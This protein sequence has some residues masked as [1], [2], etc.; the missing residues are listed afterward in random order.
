LATVSGHHTPRTLA[1][2]LAKHHAPADLPT[3]LYH[4]KPT[5]QAVVEK[6]CAKLKGVELTV[7]TLGEQ[8]LL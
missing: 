2:D 6:E 4:I 7:L 1:L 3:L 5:F 8:L